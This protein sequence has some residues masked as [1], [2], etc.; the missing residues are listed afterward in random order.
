MLFIQVGHRSLLRF[1]EMGTIERKL[2]LVVE[3]DARLRPVLV[4]ALEDLGFEVKQA[5]SVGAATEILAEYVPQLL[6]LDVA[7]PDGRALDLLEVIERISPRPS[8]VAVSGSAGPDESFR[9]AERGVRAYLKKPLQLEELEQAVARALSEPP[10]L[11]PHLKSAVGRVPIK[12]VEATVRTTM[13]EEALGHGK[14]S[15]RAA[16][17]VLGISRQLLQHILRRN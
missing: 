8:V 9:L 12:D 1:A 15:R 2:A 4:E 10:D 14:G 16:A 11:A 17:R 7:L 6:L 5:G 3:D 13:V